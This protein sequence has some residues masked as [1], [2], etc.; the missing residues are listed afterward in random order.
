MLKGLWHRNIPD[1]DSLEVMAVEIEDLEN[2]ELS[3]E[4]AGFLQGYEED[5]YELYDEEAL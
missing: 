5:S 2:D 1:S 3:V 4:E